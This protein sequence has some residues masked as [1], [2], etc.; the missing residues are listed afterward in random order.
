[1][2]KYKYNIGSPKRTTKTKTKTK[3][4]FNTLKKYNIGRPAKVV[5]APETPDTPRSK[6]WTKTRKQNAYKYY[7]IRDYEPDEDDE[8]LKNMRKSGAPSPTSTSYTTFEAVITPY[9]TQ[10]LKKKPLVD[11]LQEEDIDEEAWRQKKDDSPNKLYSELKPLIPGKV[12]RTR[13]AGGRT[14]RKNRSLRKDR[15]S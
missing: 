4:S 1:M 15:H 3:T 14:R 12:M 8:I 13:R 7:E 11:T 5:A 10:A 2:K 6:V 9:M